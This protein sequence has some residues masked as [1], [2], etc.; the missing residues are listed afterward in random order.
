[1]LGIVLKSLDRCLKRSNPALKR[2]AIRQFHGGIRMGP[3]TISGK[4]CFR[5]THQ[6][7]FKGTLK[8][9]FERSEKSMTLRYLTDLDSLALTMPKALRNK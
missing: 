4:K 2:K 7:Y 6:T 8:A 3:R 9:N 5:A 1:V